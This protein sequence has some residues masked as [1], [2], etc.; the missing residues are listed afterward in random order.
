MFGKSDSKA[1]SAKIDTLIGQKT[2]L[3]GDIVFSGGLHIDGVLRGNVFAEQEGGSVVSLSERGLIEGEV[4]VA[5]VIINGTVI[6]D[7]YAASH[8]ELAA[9]ARIKGNVYYRVIEM[10]GGA[11]VNG[12]LV[13]RRENEELDEED[14]VMPDGQQ[15]ENHD[16]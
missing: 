10:A 5:N 16:S 2:E 15:E 9:Q 8:L 4:R 13:H 3:R 1:K 12:K 7:V 14:P 11:E 6:G